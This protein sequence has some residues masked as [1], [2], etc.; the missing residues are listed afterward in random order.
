M[1]GKSSNTGDLSDVVKRLERLEEIVERLQGLSGAVSLTEE[2]MTI[3]ALFRENGTHAQNFMFDCEREHIEPEKAVHYLSQKRLQTTDFNEIRKYKQEIEKL[4]DGIKK[5]RIFTV[6]A[7][8]ES[9]YPVHEKRTYAYV[10]EYCQKYNLTIQ[11]IIDYFN[12]SAR[13]VTKARS[14]YEYGILI[15]LQDKLRDQKDNK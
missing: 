5:K 8:Y 1:S 15:G 7:A 13:G 12:P 10:V 9:G 3:E 6:A 14:E 2:E 4:A 11:D